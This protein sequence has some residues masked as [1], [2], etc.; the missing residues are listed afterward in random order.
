MTESEF[1]KLFKKHYKQVYRHAFYLLKNNE[2]AEDMTQETFI[3]AWQL[4]NELR[5][6]TVHSWLLKC[7]QNLCF[8]E[9][10]RQKYQVYTSD[11]FTNV[12]DN[13]HHS[14]SVQHVQS[15]EKSVCNEETK[16]LVHQAIGK[17]PPRLRLIVVMREL[18]GMSYSEI[19][20]VMGIPEGTV[21]SKLYRAR[22]KLRSILSNMLEK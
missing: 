22:K 8:N 13:L 16:R 2:D 6:S 1:L 14:E 21:K 3:K 11:E 7:V 17:L 5:P 18:D 20:E 10:K 4:K 9:L 19:S 12:V 15:P